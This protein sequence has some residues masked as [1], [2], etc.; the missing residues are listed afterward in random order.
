MLDTPSPGRLNGP[1]PFVRGD[2]NGDAKLDISD[3]IAI[4]AYLFSGSETDCEDALDGND[5][6]KIDIADA[7][8]VLSYLFGGGPHPP[9]PFPTAGADTTG[10]VLDC[11]RLGFLED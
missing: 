4:L 8:Y 10:E 3:A 2:A 6:D 7:I 11:E 1:F 5:S 9:E